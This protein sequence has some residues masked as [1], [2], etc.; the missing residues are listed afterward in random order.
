MLTLIPENKSAEFATRERCQIK[1]ILNDDK[2]PNLSIARCRVLP[3]ITTE[4]HSLS[5]TAETYLIENGEGLM[6]DGRCSPLPVEAGDCISI[7]P[8]HAQR[9][10]N[11]GTGELKFLVICTPRFK[12]A[13]Y[14]SKESG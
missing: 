2:S 12:P 9:I 1:E 5:G 3:G 7:S 13:C 4:L 6:D 11:T 8:G 14:A 10:K